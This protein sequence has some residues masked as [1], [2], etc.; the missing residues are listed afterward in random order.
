MKLVDN[1]LKEIVSTEEAA[2]A[3][4]TGD[5]EMKD[6]AGDPRQNAKKKGGGSGEI[7]EGSP[8]S[9]SYILQLSTCARS[10]CLESLPN[11]SCFGCFFTFSSEA[12]IPSVG[13]PA[14]P[15]S[16][17]SS[18]VFVCGAILRFARC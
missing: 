8:L 7:Q 9:L 17:V 1:R 6:A 14:P 13:S 5:V 2:N 18:C 10:L 11:L 15:C 16:P 12:S 4:G 3:D